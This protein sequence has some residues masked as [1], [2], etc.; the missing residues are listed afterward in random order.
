MSDGERAI[1]YMIGQT[2]VAE[3]N[4]L[5]IIDEPELHIHRS[6]MSRLWDELESIRPDCA[7]VFITHDLDFAAARSAKKFVIKSHL[8]PTGWEIEEVPTDTG[9]D[10]ET[11]TLILGSRRPILFVEGSGASLDTAIYRSC[12]PEWTVIP[13]GSCEE[14]IHSVVTM[15][16]NSAL[17]RV[18]CAGIVDADGQTE[19]D[20]SYLRERGVAVLPVAEIENIFLLPPVSQAIAEHEGHTGGGLDELMETLKHRV[21]DTVRADMLE[22]VITRHCKRRIDRHIKRT[23][24]NASRTITELAE[25]FS[26]AMR[27]IDISAIAASMRSNLETAQSNA[28]LTSLLQHYD[29]KGLLAMF[30]SHVRR[31]SRDAFEGWLTRVLRNQSIPA[32]TETLR[33]VLPEVQA[34]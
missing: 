6:I 28:D 20:I 17:T 27:A 3:A 23:G 21:F 24:L 11:S 25:E 14:V 32:L 16:A 19:A 22:A 33:R 29:N 4:S 34:A 13:R 10:E 8:M 9:F 5:L 1:F 2:L 12:Y 18:T 15:R 30:A 7:F 26:S 31:S